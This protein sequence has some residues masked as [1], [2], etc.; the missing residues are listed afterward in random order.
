MILRIIVGIIF[1]PYGLYLIYK[2]FIKSNSRNSIPEILIVKLNSNSYRDY[3]ENIS[4]GDEVSL[5]VPE[6]KKNEV[7][8]YCMNT[9]SGK[10]LL[11]VFKNKPIYKHLI[12]EKT[13]MISYSGNRLTCKILEINATSLK[14]SIST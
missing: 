7:R 2:H 10:G 1:W 3:I 12:N 5:W 6:K 4:I 13:A 11:S 9:D 8:V 14:I